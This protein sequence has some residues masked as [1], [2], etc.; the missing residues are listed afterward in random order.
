[1][2]KID[3][4]PTPKTHSPAAPMR[5]SWRSLTESSPYGLVTS[6]IIYSGI[7]PI[8]LLD[9]F[10]TTYQAVCFKSYGLPKVE[11]RRYFIY[12][13]HRLPYLNLIERI[14]CEYCAYFNGVIAYAREVAGRTEQHFC[15][16]RNATQ[17]PAAHDQYKGFEAYGDASGYDK[18]VRGQLEKKAP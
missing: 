14:N 12:D 15:P 3:A 16:I 8:V 10:A 5:S 11:R 18:V 13:R 6:P 1:M 2:E 17:R 7:V 4:L 9:L